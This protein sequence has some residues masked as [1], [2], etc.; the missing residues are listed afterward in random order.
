MANTNNHRMSLGDEALLWRCWRD[1]MAIHGM[2]WRFTVLRV[3]WVSVQRLCIF[4]WR[5]TEAIARQNDGG[6]PI[7]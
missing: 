3:R 5:S 1:G 6:D 2:G 7:N 4:I